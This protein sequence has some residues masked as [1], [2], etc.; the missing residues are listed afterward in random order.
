VNAIIPVPPAKGQVSNIC[1]AGKDFNIMYITCWDKVFR[2]K[3]KTKGANNF[4]AP[5][6]PANPRL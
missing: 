1:F 4:A 2:R 3:I 5:I 6:R